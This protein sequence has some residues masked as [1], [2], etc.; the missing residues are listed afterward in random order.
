MY[1]PFVFLGVKE[2]PRRLLSLQSPTGLN[3]LGTILNTLWLT[4]PMPPTSIPTAQ[5]NLVSIFSLC[6]VSMS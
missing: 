3:N 4:T 1:V 2:S 6:N 5:A